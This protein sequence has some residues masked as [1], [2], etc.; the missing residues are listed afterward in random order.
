M[1]GLEQSFLAILH[2][3]KISIYSLSRSNENI[4][5]VSTADNET[6]ESKPITLLLQYEH[7]LTRNA[8]NFTYGTFGGVKGRDFICVQS[9]DGLLSFFEQES[10][11]FAR[12]L[13]GFLIPGPIQYF[14]HI[15]SF[16]TGSSRGYLESYK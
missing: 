16:L 9:M 4:A 14:S 2:P 13:P 1:A 6:S 15:D 3:R 8:E 7:K 12:F 11:A 5:L 10:S